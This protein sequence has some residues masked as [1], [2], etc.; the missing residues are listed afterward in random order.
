[1]SKI[2]EH[3]VEVKSVHLDSYGHV[4]NAAFLVLFED[5]RWQ[6]L[7]ESQMGQEYVAQHREGPVLIDLFI[8]YKKELKEGEVVKVSTFLTERHGTR[9]FTIE[10]I[11]YH[12]SGKI[13]AEVKMTMG[14][15]DLVLRKLIPVS[16]QWITALG[17]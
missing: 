15:M 4:N 9:F 1:M 17:G 12:P 7:N 2:F 5:A 11:M 14:M 6:V 8:K 10:Q 16:D 13:A 3:F